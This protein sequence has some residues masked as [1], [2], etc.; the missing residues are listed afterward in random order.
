MISSRA[1]SRGFTLVEL[2]VVIAIVGILTAI[3]LPAVQSA[4]EA[5]RRVSCV[6]NVKQLTLACLHFESRHGALPYARK[7]DLP[8]AYTWTQLILPQIEQQDVQDMYFDLFVKDGSASPQYE[9]RPYGPDQRKR[10]ARLAQIPQFYCPSDQSPAAS[11]LDS[12]LWGYWRGNYRGC[13]GYIQSVRF[14]LTN[15][16]QA[17]AFTIRRFQGPRVYGGELDGKPPEQ[18]RLSDIVDG[19]THTLL[20]SEGIAPVSSQNYCGPLGEVIS[21]NIGGALFDAR[22]APNSNEPDFIERICPRDGG[23]VEYPA[24]CQF[25]ATN[26]A[27]ATAAARSYHRSGVVASR[28]DGS[29]TFIFEDIDLKA[30][31]AAGTR[32]GEEIPRAVD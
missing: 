10:T 31:Q 15:S 30:W 12:P 29:V 8:D 5:A 21:G 7:A 9:Y 11:E 13:L 1:S 6:N 4:R 20:V 14:S 18:V 24:P 28:V 19:T 27:Q 22:L 3:L 32:A 16:R 2:L 23:D 25:V 26:N 17:G